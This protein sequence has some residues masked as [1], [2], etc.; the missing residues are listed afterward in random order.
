MN[1]ENNDPKQYLLLNLIRTLNDD[2]SKSALIAGMD[3]DKI[4]T[5]YPACDS[6]VIQTVNSDGE[7]SYSPF[8]F[9]VKNK[10]D[11]LDEDGL[12][13]EN[14]SGHEIQQLLQAGEKDNFP[15]FV[16]TR[17]DTFYHLKRGDRIIDCN[18]EEIFVMS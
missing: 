4:A 10:N 3:C 12:L 2:V 17:N 15:R 16:Q 5:S 1:D 7:K 13:E 11:L 6:Y 14:H 9:I 8:T 18:A